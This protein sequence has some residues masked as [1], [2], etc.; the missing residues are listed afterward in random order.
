MK[1]NNPY[2]LKVIQFLREE[3]GLEW[4]KDFIK[5]CLKGADYNVVRYSLEDGCKCIGWR[6]KMLLHVYMREIE[7]DEWMNKLFTSL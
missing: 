5:N 2:S 6:L 3:L 7:K 1:I 4:S